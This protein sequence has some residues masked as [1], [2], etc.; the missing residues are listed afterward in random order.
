[1]SNHKTLAAFMPLFLILF[2]DGMGLS[3]LFPVLNSIIIDVHSNFLPA[4]ASES[5]RNFLYGLTVSIFMICWFFGATILGDLSDKTG[6]K[7]ALLIC[8]VGAFAGYLLSAL[9][10]VGQSLSFLILGRVIAG[11]T[12]GSQPI[13]QAAIIDISPPE[14]KARNIGLILLAIAL[15]FTIGPV[16]GGFLSDNKFVSWFSFSTPLFFASLISLLNA[17]L[18]CG[19]FKETSTHAG[20]I[21]IR[22][23][24]AISV[25]ISAFQHEKIRLLSVI[26]LVM[27]FGWSNFFTFLPMFSL[28]RYSFTPLETSLLLAVMGAGFSIGFAYLIDRLVKHWDLKVIVTYSF[29][30]TAVGILIIIF[31]QHPLILWLLV[32]PIGVFIAVGY[33]ALITLF[34]NLVNDNEQGWVMGVTGSVMALCFGITALSTGYLADFGANFSMYLAAL[35][36]GLSGFLMFFLSQWINNT[37]SS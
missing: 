14:H 36:T 32:G 7:K 4:A 17:F 1:M 3:L 35:G 16:I 22:L 26:L 31:M 19:L 8:L 6:R 2:I 34:S 24:Q 37:K 9:A 23:H 29:W 12:A 28:K 10:V 30:A 11:F 5:T 21:R 15:G 20:K 33:S 27:I 25:F 13:A 18:L